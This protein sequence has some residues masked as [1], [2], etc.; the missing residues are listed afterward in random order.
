M[1]FA[2]F[3]ITLYFKIFDDTESGVAEL[4]K[5]LFSKPKVSGSLTRVISSRFNR[6]IVTARELCQVS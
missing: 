4:V 5:R 6:E 3:P 2:I 1:Y